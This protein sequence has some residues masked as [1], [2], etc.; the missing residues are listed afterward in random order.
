MNNHSHKIR[1]RTLGIIIRDIRRQ[2]GF[3]DIGEFARRAGLTIQ[4]VQAWET[5]GSEPRLST[6]QRIAARLHVRLLLGLMPNG[7]IHVG[8]YTDGR[9][10]ATDA[11]ADSSAPDPCRDSYG[12]AD[13]N[14][15]RYGAAD[16]NRD[17][18]GAADLNRDRYGAD[19]ASVQSLVQPA[20]RPQPCSSP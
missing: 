7:E 1:P 6:L 3:D 5:T 13:L 8:V 19:P 2:C 15:D 4:Q 12:A 20:R 11:P 10:P 16:L 14:R 9:A 18:Y 17:R